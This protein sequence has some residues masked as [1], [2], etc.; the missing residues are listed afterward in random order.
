MSHDSQYIDDGVT[1]YDCV[2]VVDGGKCQKFRRLTFMEEGMWV[3]FDSH[4]FTECG[5]DVL[6]NIVSSS[7]FAF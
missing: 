6:I 5:V 4:L 3:H 1:V 2:T 7:G